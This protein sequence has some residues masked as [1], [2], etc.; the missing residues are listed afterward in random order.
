MEY[1]FATGNAHKLEELRR[2]A[3]GSGV[4]FV[5]M[6]DAGADLDIAEDGATFAENAAIKAL[7]AARATG[8]YALADDSG[9][10]V[11]Y[12]GGAPGALSARFMGE[13]TPYSVKNAEIIRLLEGTGEEGRGA[14]FVCVI[15]LSAPDG[16]VITETGEVA[17]VIAKEPSGGGGFG[18]DP[19]FLIPELGKTAAELSP[20]E[21][22]AVSHRGKALRK[23]LARIA[24]GSP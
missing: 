22:D 14:R 8:R 13:D 17:G 7:A 10:C 20:A 2:I 5:S 23:M 19:I 12:L 21:K 9:L 1:V 16:T 15:A 18:Y 4:A 11:D 3:A 24:G 6:K